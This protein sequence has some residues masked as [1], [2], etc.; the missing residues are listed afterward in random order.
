MTSITLRPLPITAERFAPFGDVICASTSVVSAMNEARFERF[1][2]MANIDVDES[3]GGHVAISIVRCRTA[4][5]LPYRFDLVERHPLGSQAFIPLSPFSFI[6]V[7]A[8]KGESVLPGDLHAFVTNGTQGINYHRGVW[9]M[10]LIAMERGQ[11]FLLVDRAPGK[12]NCDEVVFGD[13]VLLE[14]P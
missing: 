6:V 12:S 10:P 4:T 9:H 7:V 13:S 2:D 11:S 1:D 8:E 5:K 3:A 14:A